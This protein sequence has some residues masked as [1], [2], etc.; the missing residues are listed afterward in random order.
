M[1]KLGNLAL[2]GGI[3]I[4]RR[5]PFLPYGLFR[6]RGP[7]LFFSPTLLFFEEVCLGQYRETKPCISRSWT[8]TLKSYGKNPIAARV[9][10]WTEVL[11]ENGWRH[12]SP[13]YSKQAVSVE[14]HIH[15]RGGPADRFCSCPNSAV[16]SRN[17]F[18]RASCQL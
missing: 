2:E 8:Q 11:E 5:Q 18:Q 1:H 10:L 16:L 13:K 17:H 4:S 9:V 7:S 14:E 12:K 6:T 15:S 3:V